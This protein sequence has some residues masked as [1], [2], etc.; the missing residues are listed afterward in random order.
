MKI[1]FHI[2]IVDVRGTSV[3]AYDYAHYNEILLHNKSIIVS[4]SNF[5]DKCD[6][7][8]IKRFKE[9]FDVRFYVDLN[10]LEMTISDCDVLYVIKY[11]TNDGVL[12]K[13]KKTLIHCV[14]NM[15][16]HHGDVY[17]G[18]SST[19]A[20]KFGKEL[21]VPHMIGLVPDN[22][23]DLREELGI[24][25]N[26]LVFGRY[27]GMDTFDLGFVHAMVEL[28]SIE[29]ENKIFFL[30]ANTPVFCNRPNVIH[31]DKM[32]NESDKN[33]FITTC[34]AHLECG[35][36]GHTFGLAMGE[37][38]VNNKPII[39]YLGQVWNSAHY[40]ILRNNAIYFSTSEEFYNAIVTFDKLK[41]QSLDNNCYREYSPQNV[42][43]IFQKV[44]LD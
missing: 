23:H 31:L 42:M 25:K 40:E 4:P 14:F 34:D 29:Y 30:F 13:I 10:D 27:G 33:K 26:A 44:F 32:V 28:I 1:A 5:M 43:N 35:S 15:T 24:P 37:F 7:I 12:S 17:A 20:H 3:A 38:S 9:R 11:G 21:F 6:Q 39:A 41:W 22:S 18:V 16:E 19:L 8:A 36:L 2:P